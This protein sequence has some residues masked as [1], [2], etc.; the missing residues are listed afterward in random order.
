[1]VYSGGAQECSAVSGILLD[2]V[3]HLLLVGSSFSLRP[4]FN[5]L[6]IQETKY[7]S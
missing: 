7:L 6:F 5:M 3:N 2:I 1:M 4:Y